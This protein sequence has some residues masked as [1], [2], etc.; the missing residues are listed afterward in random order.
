MDEFLAASEQRVAMSAQPEKTNCSELL[1]ASY[2]LRADKR[3][4]RYLLFATRYRILAI[5]YALNWSR[6]RLAQG[7]HA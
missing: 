5:R 3:A 2:L 4:I 6:D 1:A 7:I